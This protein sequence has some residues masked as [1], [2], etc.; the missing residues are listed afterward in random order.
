MKYDYKAAKNFFSQKV[1]GCYA[2]SNEDNPYK[3]YLFYS[4]NYIRAKK[5][6]KILEEKPK[7]EKIEGE[8]MF[9]LNLQYKCVY[10]RTDIYNVFYDNFDFSFERIMNLTSRCFNDL[11]KIGFIQTSTYYTEFQNNKEKEIKDSPKS[12]IVEYKVITKILTDNWKIETS[13]YKRD[14]T[15]HYYPI[16]KNKHQDIHY[17]KI[18][19]QSFKKR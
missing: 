10:I 8:L 14:N 3:I 18:N 12:T 4:K 1:N 7:M 16:P 9:I 6:C 2:V 19:N 15:E 5:L 17:R 11:L 13:K